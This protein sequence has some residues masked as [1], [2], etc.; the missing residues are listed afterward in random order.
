MRT[1]SE[2][3]RASAA[4]W[5]AVPSTSAVSVLVIDCTTIGAPPPTVTPPTS[6]A[7]D[8]WRSCAL[9]LMMYPGA[10]L[11]ICGQR[12]LFTSTR[13]VATSA[14]AAAKAGVNGSPSTRWPAA[15]PNK[16]V[17]NVNTDSLLAEYFAITAN[18][19][20]KVTL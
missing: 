11:T 1:S 3:A 16:G 4:T 18:Q 20:T 12:A 15:T 10:R 14:T 2:P 8:L 17:R 7:T 5:R 19:T 6:T 9:V 13:P